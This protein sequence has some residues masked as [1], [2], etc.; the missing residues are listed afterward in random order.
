M[1]ITIL[2]LFSLT[3]PFHLLYMDHGK[4]TEI[5]TFAGCFWIILEP[6]GAALAMIHLTRQHFIR[7]LREM[8]GFCHFPPCSLCPLGSASRPLASGNRPP[9]TP[10]CPSACSTKTMWKRIKRAQIIKVRLE[11]TEEWI[12][13]ST[14]NCEKWGRA[15]GRRACHF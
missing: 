2:N 8:H 10:F 9:S 6:W 13:M 12:R 15:L 4:H 5:K 1:I 14:R 7:D 11:N 3:W